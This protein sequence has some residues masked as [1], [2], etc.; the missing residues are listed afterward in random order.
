MAISKVIY[1]NQT[2]LD[3]S[4]DTVAADKLLSGY[5]AHGSDGEA[6]N[7]SCTFDAD[8]KDAT[9][10]ASEIL[11]TKTAYKNGAKIT[12]TM[13]NNGA[14]SGS[15]SDVSTPYTVPAG[16]HDG[17]GTVGVDSTEAA[18]IIPENIRE[19]VEI[20]GVEGSMSGSEDVKATT[21]NVTPYTTSQTI[22]PSDLGDYNSITQINVAAIAYSETDNAGGGKTATI[23]T[24]APSP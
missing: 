10:L 22:I 15:I 11:A 5:T 23:G 4:Q 21:A 14:V 6:I 3:I 12:G 9:A 18:K 8:T 2:L 16:Y 17:S 1:G 13:P 7:G 19:G 24:V 20:L